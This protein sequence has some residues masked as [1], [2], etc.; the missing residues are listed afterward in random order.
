LGERALALLALI[1]E[2]ND[3]PLLLIRPASRSRPDNRWVYGVVCTMLEP[4]SAFEWSLLRKAALNGFNDR[5]VDYG[6]IQTL[7]LIASPRSTRILEEASHRNPERA[8]AIATALEYIRS[9]PRRYRTETWTSWQDGPLRPSE[10]GNW[11]KSPLLST[12]KS[13]TRR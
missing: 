2:T 8:K 4:L 5:W 3:R 7:K 13:A 10:L 11:K 9:N 1:G 12:I 6:A